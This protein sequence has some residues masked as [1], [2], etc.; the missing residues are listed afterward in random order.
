MLHLIQGN[1]CE[2]PEARWATLTQ[3]HSKALEVTKKIC[4]TQEERSKGNS[5][6][7]SRNWLI[8]H[9][10]GSHQVRCHTQAGVLTQSERIILM[11]TP[12]PRHL[13]LRLLLCCAHKRIA[14]QTEYGLAVGR[15]SMARENSTLRFLS[16]IQVIYNLST[17]TDLSPT[18]NIYSFNSLVGV[19]SGKIYNWFTANLGFQ[20]R[21]SS[22]SRTL[23]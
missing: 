18:K 23:I 3:D 19:G 16:W 6:M 4:T 8:S 2:R 14:M 12:S 9:H 15:Q 1:L 5:R 17:F 7:R 22:V 20:K 11:L 13:K 10:H 21:C